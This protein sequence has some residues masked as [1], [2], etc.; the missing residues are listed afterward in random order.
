MSTTKSTIRV[1]NLAQQTLLVCELQGQMSD[2]F[3][4]NSSPHD[5]WEKPACAD[6]VVDPENVG[7]DF[8]PRRSY[9]FANKDLLDVVGDRMIG[10]VKAKIAFPHLDME[11]HWDWELSDFDPKQ[12]AFNEYWT[13]KNARQVELFGMPLVDAIEKINAVEYT[14]TQLI[15]DLKALGKIF[16]TARK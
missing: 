6:V 11:N 8:Y 12:T 2:G 13:K 5:H 3:W 7:M 16:S 14:R 4:E 1:H 9:N 15:K 10:F